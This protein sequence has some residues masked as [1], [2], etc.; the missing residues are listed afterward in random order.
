MSDLSAFSAAIRKALWMIQT[1]I[2]EQYLL[3]GKLFWFIRKQFWFIEKH[4]WLIEKEHRHKAVR[5]LF[6][7]GIFHNWA[8]VFVETAGR[9]SL[10][11]IHPSLPDFKSFLI[12][13]YE[14]I[15][16]FLRKLWLSMWWTTGR[17]VI[18][19]YL[20]TNRIA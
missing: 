7:G 2:K 6:W 10:Q 1:E 8:L 19:I 9:P 4:F 20:P 5:G 11:N 14:I 3:I 16:L 18:N 12:I 15:W 17:I 13:C